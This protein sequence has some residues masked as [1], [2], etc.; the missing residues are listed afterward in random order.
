MVIATAYIPSSRPSEEQKG[1]YRNL[2]AF[3]WE[4][5]ANTFL[6]FANFLVNFGIDT[7]SI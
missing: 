4:K 2:K 7:T 1:I 3:I 6:G 5:F